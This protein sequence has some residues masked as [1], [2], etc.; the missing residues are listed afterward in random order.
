MANLFLGFPVP[1][2]KIADMISGSAPPSLHKTQHQDGGT[3]EIDVTGLVGAGGLT[4]PFTDFIYSAAFESLDGY[5]FT[6]VAGGAITLNGE[7]I[8]LE[9]AGASGD[10]YSIRKVINHQPVPMTWD[11]KKAFITAARLSA[12][13]SS[14][15]YQFVGMG[16][17]VSGNCLGFAVIN[18]LFQAIAKTGAGTEAYTIANWSAGAYDQ[19]KRLKIIHNP[20][21]S[22]QFYVDEVL[23]YTATTQIPAEATNASIILHAIVKNTA[24]GN[25]LSMFL[26]H[27]QYY[28]AA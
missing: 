10:E 7:Q 5:R 23:V 21:V 22:V 4:L 11:K 18:G 19:Q 25:W 20:G 15:G 6:D 1:R 3:D 17:Y 24:A 27:Y 13:G 2:A 26:S 16:T 9:T 8:Q 12:G 14:N 28:Q